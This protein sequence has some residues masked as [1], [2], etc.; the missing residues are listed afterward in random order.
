MKLATKKKIGRNDP[1]WCGSGN[2][3]KKC[4]LR[5]DRQ[6]ASRSG[7][8]PS[9]SPWKRANRKLR[10]E[11]KSQ[12]QIE[13]IRRAGQLTREILTKLEDVVKVGVSTEAIDRWVHDYTIAKGA[14]PATLG[15]KG[16]PKSTCT[17][18]NEVVCHGI[19][20]PGRI[21]QDGD[22]INVDITSVLDGYFGDASCMYLVGNVNDEARRLVEVTKQCLDLGV[23]AIRP[24]A[25]VG[26]IGH[27]IQTHAEAEGFSVVRQFV[28]HGIGTKFHESLQ[29]PHFGRPGEGPWLAPGMVFTVEPMINAG[30]Y[31]VEI[32][33]DEWTA[34]TRDGSWSAQWEH[35][36]A[37]TEDG[38]DILTA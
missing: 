33:D 27:A 5:E 25:R 19:P 34:V 6:G 1:C 3:Y 38:V 26:D 4:H 17:S 8:S 14:R 28:G 9:R 22:I 7:T 29:I 35:T 16:Y 36:V 18:I 37:V 15:Y 23:A 10:I 21:L 2:K 11:L 30:R 12:E 31:G 24:D 32:L 13:G 20:E